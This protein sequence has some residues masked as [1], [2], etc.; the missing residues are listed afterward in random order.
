MVTGLAYTPVGGEILFVEVAMVTG[1]GELRLTGQLGDVMRE[2]ALAASSILRG[3]TRAGATDGDFGR[4]DTHVHVPAGAI[5]KDGPS[6]GVAILSAMTSALTGKVVDPSIGMTGEITLSGRVLPIGGVR[7]KILAAHRA[8]LKTVIL[9]AKNEEDLED[10]PEE[11]LEQLS[12]VFVENIE[13]LL[14]FVFPEAQ[15]EKPPAKA[16]RK[17]KTKTKTKKKA[18][19]TR[20]VTRKKAAKSKRPSTK[21]TRAKKVKKKTTP[22]RAAKTKRATSRK[23]TRTKR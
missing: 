8:G 7:E 14:E 9:P 17:K 6:A 1:S 11:V 16:A 3:W 19:A 20:K 12:F 21:S 22:K 2:S 5:P 23:K 13:D 18:P 4:W 15:Q 10:V